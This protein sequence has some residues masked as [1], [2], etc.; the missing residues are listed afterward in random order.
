MSNDSRTLPFSLL[1][2]FMALLLTEIVL[3]F[4]LEIRFHRRFCVNGSV[5]VALF[6]GS[7]TDA[8]DPSSSGGEETLAERTEAQ[9]Q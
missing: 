8:A 4:L 6:R 1:H 2:H 5:D 9:Q 3:L 7:F